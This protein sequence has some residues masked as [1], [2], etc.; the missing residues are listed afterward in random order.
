MPDASFFNKRRPERAVQR[1]QGTSTVLCR[2]DPKSKLSS[3]PT[4]SILSAAYGFFFG[5]VEDSLAVC[6]FCAQQVKDDASKLV[7]RGCDRLRPAE[8]AGD[9][10]D[11]FTQIVLRVVESVSAHAQGRRDAAADASAFGEQH[12]AAADLLLR[13]EP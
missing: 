12:F 13:T 10:A 7:G 5:L 4:Q 9:A 11:E 1:S 2:D 8:F 6:L 3:L